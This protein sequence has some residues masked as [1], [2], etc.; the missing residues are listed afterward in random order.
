M[1]GKAQATKAPEETLGKALDGVVDPQEKRVRIG[2]TFVDVFRDEAKSIPGARFLAQ[3]TL[4]PD[5]IESG[6]DRDGPAA[7]RRST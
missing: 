2:H 5:V 4:Y 7:G 3:G 6:G 1:S